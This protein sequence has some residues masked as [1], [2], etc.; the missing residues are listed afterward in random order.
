M[1]K[2]PKSERGSTESEH[3]RQP[4]DNGVKCPK[5]KRYSALL[6]GYN[7]GD[8]YYRCSA[9]TCG[10]QWEA[11]LGET[12]ESPP[13]KPPRKPSWTAIGELYAR[14]PVDTNP[15]VASVLKMLEAREQISVQ[16]ALEAMV[17]ELVKEN[18]RLHET[19]VDLL[20]LQPPAPIT[21]LEEDRDV[22]V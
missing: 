19:T 9:L 4:V 20:K 2:T 11:K 1:A 5:C 17:I 16:R 6:V 8:R 7:T 12:P 10:Y 13:L 18:Q 22:D 15:I 21:F 3:A 14:L